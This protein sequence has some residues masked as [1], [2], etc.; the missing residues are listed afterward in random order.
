MI[1]RKI[2]R[3]LFKRYSREGN[4]ELQ[5]IILSNRTDKY[6]RNFTNPR[7]KDVQKPKELETENNDLKKAVNEIRNCLDN[8]KKIALFTDYDV[9]GC[10]SM[11]LFYKVFKENL[12]YDNIV[13]IP[14]NRFEGYGITEQA[15]ERIN[16]EN[17]DLV[18][19]ADLGITENKAIENIKSKVIVTDHHI[20]PKEKS[21]A[22]AV[23][24]PYLSK[25]SNNICGCAVAWLLMTQ[26]LE[27]KKDRMIKHLD[28]V[29]LA[30]I[31]DM[32]PMI[33]I[34]NRY[35][36]NSG[37][38]LINKKE[39]ICW[40]VFGGKIDEGYFGFSLGPKINSCSRMNGWNKDAVKY[41]I[42]NDY[43]DCQIYND[44]LDE[45]NEERKEFQKKLF[46]EIKGKSDV[47]VHYSN[48]NWNGIQGLAAGKISNEFNAVSLIMSGKD[49]IISGSAR[50]N[51]RIH[52]KDCFDVFNDKY[53]LLYKYG[54]HSAAIGFSIKKENLNQFIELI[55]PFI[56][57]RIKEKELY[58]DLEM[59]YP[60][61]DT[62][63]QISYLKPFGI[64]FEK[65]LFLGN[66]KLKEFKQIGKTKEHCSLILNGLKAVYFFS[67][68]DHEYLKE[69][70]NEKINVL[71]EIDENYFRGKTTMQLM[72]KEIVK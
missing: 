24:N 25:Y 62:L 32:V 53:N 15:V 47:V 39:K 41:L 5:S 31:A 63:E 35:F 61:Y 27:N 44:S 21:N 60:N 8:N 6:I 36:V 43:N 7:I 69:K 57:E 30:T 1:K 67:V 45:S 34:N 9:D 4:S 58:Y 10:T 14:S 22:F 56:K 54:G 65:P 11:A 40:R 18:I 72:V 71:Y 12:N 70:V 68:N 49:D 23:L 19:T 13:F 59:D 28:Y 3:E 16:K 51:D 42:S 52:L 17:P 29:A 50:S 20:P 38:N 2:N 33:D 66:F 37:I 55:E 46:D 64:K 48:N 26:V